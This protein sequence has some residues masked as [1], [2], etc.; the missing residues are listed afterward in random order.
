MSIT[1]PWVDLFICMAQE[2]IATFSHRVPGKTLQR[3]LTG[4]KDCVSS[5]A[6]FAS[7]HG[8]PS[9]GVVNLQARTH[10]LEN[11]V[12]MSGPRIGSVEAQVR[13]MNKRLK[14]WNPD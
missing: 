12:G 2:F 8:S 1:C 3:L 4:T 14:H 6:M 7:R 9:V 11:A 5:C 10:D 13:D